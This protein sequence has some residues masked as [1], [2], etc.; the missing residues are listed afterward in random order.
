[1]ACKQEDYED[2]K[3]TMPNQTMQ[4]ADNRF[5]SQK[6]K[7]KW[8]VPSVE[9]E[10]IF[11]LQAE[12]KAMKRAT[13]DGKKRKENPKKRRDQREKVDKAWIRT[14]LSSLDE[15]MMT[16]GSDIGKFNFYVQTL[17]GS[18]TARCETSI[19]LRLSGT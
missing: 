9:E 8:N 17:M 19:Y 11:A 5:K 7:N 1:M 6:L 4:T 16:I 12:V 2:G 15:Y 14:Q 10:K 18:L 13:K 3:D